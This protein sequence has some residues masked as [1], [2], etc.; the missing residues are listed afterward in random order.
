M[1]N[2]Q[3]RQYKLFYGSSY[4]R[5]LQHLLNMWSD[6]K[7]AIPS[8]TLDICYGWDLFLKAYSNNPERMAWKKR[9]DELMSQDGIVH[10]GRLGKKE[11]SE[12][13]SRCGIWAYPTHFEEIHCITA[14]ECQ[15]D[16]LVPVVINLAALD[17][18]V[19]SGIKI[20]GDIAMQETSEL[21][22]KSL[23][24]MMKDEKRWKEE[25][26]KAIKFAKKHTWNIVAKKWIKYL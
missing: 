21:F 17:E 15:L 22:K 9:M 11:L 5:G 6:I 18:T 26:E 24:D 14:L 20:D 3:L 2:K 13:R 23:I 12:V 19:Q 10:H 7:E 16:G 25:S 1:S 4:D 8:A